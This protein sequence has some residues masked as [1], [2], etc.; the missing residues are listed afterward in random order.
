LFKSGVYETCTACH[1]GTL[2]FYNV[3]SG[4]TAGTFSGT[5][6][7]NASV[8]LATG[9]MDVKAAP[10]GNMLVDTNGTSGKDGLGESTWQGEFTCSSCHA[11]HGSYSSRLL[12]FNP[13]G[14]ASVPMYDDADGTYTGTSAVENGGKNAST[15]GQ[16]VRELVV[17]AVPTA[18]ADSP[19]YVVY[20]TTANDAKLAFTAEFKAQYGLADTDPIVVVMKKTGDGHGTPYSY[21]RDTTPWIF[22]GEYKEDHSY[23]VNFTKFY[24]GAALSTLDVSNETALEATYNYDSQI[25]SGVSFN[26]QQAFV[27]L[28]ATMKDKSGKAANDPNSY[29]TLVGQQADISRAV[30]VT[31][32]MDAVNYEWFGSTDS[33]VKI[34]QV[35]PSNYSDAAQGVATSTFCAACHTDYLAKSADT[36]GTGVWSK[37]FR[38][39]T[40]SANYTC[41]KCHFAHGT[42]VTVML[43]AQDRD[44]EKAAID[45]FGYNTANP[46]EDP[47][48]ITA[49]DNATA[50]LLDKNPSSA[51]KR[52]TNMAVCWKCHTSSHSV[53]LMN[54]N[55]V[56][57]VKYDG[58]YDGTTFTPD[59][60]NN[61]T[62][63]FTAPANAALPYFKDA[64]DVVKTP[65]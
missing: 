2:G 19:A 41:L 28:S 16:M 38:H 65:Q 12:H 45:L 42:D 59:T 43:D 17:D 64:V 11:P 27:E 14:I 57:N 46:A 60:S 15:G 58:A 54:N 10:G 48:N 9:G 7:G 1:D 40:N 18:D 3:F 63:G 20:Q 61:L 39:T 35:S 22:G 44:V 36:V 13:N 25:T 56:Y 26:Y 51:L 50:Y 32:A 4:S 49:K 55:Y 21:V 6:D 47:A 62:N 5:H 52:Y 23:K 33:G 24:P 53:G 8:H 37:A 29:S 31:L 34:T 30:V